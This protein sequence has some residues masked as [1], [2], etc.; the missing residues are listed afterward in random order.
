MRIGIVLPSV[1]AYS[2]TFFVNKI[3]GLQRHG[4][5][6]VIFASSAGTKEFHL[7]KFKLAPKL[8][9]SKVSIVFNSLYILCLSF[10]FQFK[11]SKRLYLLDKKDGVGF[12][13]RLKN[14]ISSYHIFSEPLDWLHFGFGTMVFNKENVA[15]AIDARMAVSFRG[16]D[17][18]VYPLKHPSCYQKLWTKVNR[19][20]VIS[21]DIKELVYEN[22]FGG[23][24]E[25]IKITP[26]IDT[27]FFNYEKELHLAKESR[28][29]TVA[30]LH[31]KK[32][33]VYTLE[34]LSI[35]KSLGYS[36]H[37][38]IIGDGAEKERL[39]FAIHQLNLEGN[40]TLKGKMEHEDI[41]KALEDADIYLQYSIQEG[42]CNA[43]LE[44]QA[45]GLLSVV[46]DAEGLS[47]NIINNKT[48]WVVPKQS[49]KLLAEKLLEV[50]N[51]D[52]E[53]KQK[54]SK[55]ARERVINQFNLTKQ[56]KEF[57]NFYE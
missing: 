5:S 6:V 22:G 11:K 32:G 31:W 19:I 39:Q 27:S 41:K 15:K 28:F 21:D 10:V 30:R 20:H 50:I 45:V 24:S 55:S 9:G 7:S 33:L 48:G 47:E 54:I 1:P 2:E 44:A 57:I 51:L 35:L 56:A 3:K 26:A 42:F 17:I 53:E 16:F 14:I 25:I 43:V 36:F 37:Y 46:S 12:L 23:E 8:K 34:A 13:Q 18:G 52:D 38:T 40:V 4:F 29:V 49:P